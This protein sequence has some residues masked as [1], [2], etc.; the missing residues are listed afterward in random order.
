MNMAAP[1]TGNNVY[2]PGHKSLLFRANIEIIINV[3]PK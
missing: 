1:S 3:I 2:A